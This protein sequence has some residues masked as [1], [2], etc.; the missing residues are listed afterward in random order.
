MSGWQALMSV[1]SLPFAGWMIVAVIRDA[2][3]Q[4]EHRRR[5][6]EDMKKRCGG[7]HL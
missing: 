1:L 6:Y 4:E 7:K 3:S 5:T 2:R